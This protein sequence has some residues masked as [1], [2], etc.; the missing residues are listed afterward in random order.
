MPAHR[1]RQQ[2]R[3]FMV[4]ARVEAIVLQQ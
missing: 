2:L 3:N 4:R 1:P